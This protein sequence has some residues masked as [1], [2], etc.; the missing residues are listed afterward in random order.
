M[1]KARLDYIVRACQ[2]TGKE[3]RE[4][5]REGKGREGKGRE[6]K[7]REGKG[8][9]GKGSPSETDGVCPMGSWNVQF[10]Q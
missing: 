5:G 8:R 9:E 4:R 10:V 3:D 6:G 1:F 7:G 2:K